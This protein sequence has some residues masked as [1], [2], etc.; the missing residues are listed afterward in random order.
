MATKTGAGKRTAWQCC[1]FYAMHLREEKAT[2]QSWSEQDDERLRQVAQKHIGDWETV[3]KMFPGRTARQCKYRWRAVSEKPN[4]GRWTEEEDQRLLGAVAQQK[5]GN[6][7]AIALQ[8]ST[9]NETQCRERY[10]EVLN[11]ELD[12]SA[13][14]EAELSKLE[15][16]VAKHG[17]AWS[18]I[19]N[20]LGTKRSPKMCL[21]AWKG[22]Q[23][24]QQKNRREA[25]ASESE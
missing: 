3:S 13:F 22:M 8:V 19:A 18:S 20:E 12:K 16:L 25:T 5:R 14:T 17:T 4:W 6:W 23:R 10:E 24:K 7:T 11:P 1:K 2:A 15:S 9:R 21:R